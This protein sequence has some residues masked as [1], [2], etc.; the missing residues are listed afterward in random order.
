MLEKVE[1]LDD[2]H[3]ETCKFYLFNLDFLIYN[4]KMNEPFIKSINNLLWYIVNQ[5]RGYSRDSRKA[6]GIDSEGL[7]SKKSQRFGSLRRKNSDG[8]SLAVVLL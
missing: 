1:E 8:E 4:P 3:E 2:E 6:R 5:R 7:N